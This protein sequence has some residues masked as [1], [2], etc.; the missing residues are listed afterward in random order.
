ML[1]DALIV[2]ASV[3]GFI[4]GWKKGMLWALGSLLAVLVGIFISLKLAHALADFL[5]KQNILTGSYTLLISFILLFL[6]TMLAFRM[7][8][9]MIESL[10]DKIMLG[11]VNK[12]S[13][14]LLYTFFVLFV[15]SVFLWLA[16]EAGLIRPE[17]RTES[18]VYSLVEPIGPETVR[19]GSEYLPLCKGLWNDIRNYMHQKT[20]GFSSPETQKN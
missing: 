8:V 13:G 7:A 14:G 1:L 10:L 18:K 2:I 4:R 6:L 19:L 9:G 5:F 17:L 15:V 3:L 20:E 11:W 12:L 16:R